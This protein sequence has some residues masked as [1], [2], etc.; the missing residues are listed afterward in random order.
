MYCLHYG[1]G[2]LLLQHRPVYAQLVGDK[3]S[4]PHVNIPWVRGPYASVS[5]TRNL[6]RHRLSD[7][8]ALEL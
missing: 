4:R 3:G 7:M 1:V 6:P 2:Q 5:V 8:K